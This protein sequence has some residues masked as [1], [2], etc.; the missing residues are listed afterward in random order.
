MGSKET[1]IVAAL[2]MAAIGAV[3]E[4][5][6][7]FVA[8]PTLIRE[9]GDPITAGWLITVNGLIGTSAALMAGRLGDIYGRKSLMQW[10][11]AVAIGGSVLSASTS[12]FG[13]VLVGRSL[14]GMAGATLPLIIGILRESLPKERVPVAIGLMTTAQG[15]GTAIGLVLGGALIDHFNWQ[16]LFI[17][18]A[19]L[20]A[21]GWIAVQI[22]V[23]SRPGTPPAHRIDWAE[24]LLPL[25]GISA[26][27]LGISL[28]KDHGWLSPQVAGL[29]VVGFAILA[30]WARRSLGA[31]EPFINLRLLASRNVAIAQALQVLLAL[32]TLQV[33]LV[34]SAYTQN[35]VW[36]MA[37]LGL[38]ATIAGLAK[39]PSNFL[40]FFAGPFSGW[41]QQK[42]GMRQPV[43]LGGALATLGWALAILLPDT[44]VQV[45]ALL[46]LISFGATMLNAAIP[47]VLVE[48]VPENRTGEAIGAMRVFQGMGI[49]IGAQ[50]IAVLLSV[51]A[52]PAP[53]SD[54]LLPSPTGFRLT[55]GWIAAL[56]LVSTLLGLSLRARHEPRPAQ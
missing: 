52:L 36:T 35:P 40:S 21:V 46:C 49:A 16:T 26:I 42:R 9:F 41:L 54:A 12:H 33:V 30:I 38:S 6:M 56:T 45:I 13:L 10:M 53:G 29:V 7:I 4:I 50:I 14:Q 5:S 25:P 11:L 48:S 19:V 28:S 22:W 15:M 51:Q 32:S 24:G 3:F 8:L 47:N 31:V 17:A 37:G 23:P 20:L 44:L 27:L 18:S 2:F 39:L 1:A 55:M 34:M 43:V